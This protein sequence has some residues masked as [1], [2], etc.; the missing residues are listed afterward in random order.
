MSD[1]F[2]QNAYSDALEETLNVFAREVRERGLCPRCAAT[3]LV[4]AVTSFIDNG[5]IKHGHDYDEADRARSPFYSKGPRF[6][7]FA[8][9]G[10]TH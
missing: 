2:E 7:M 3:V 4:A 8:D 9:P 5:V 6:K 1:R 10:T